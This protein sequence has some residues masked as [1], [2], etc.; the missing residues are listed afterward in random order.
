MICAGKYVI[1]VKRISDVHRL[2]T[3][4][5]S[6]LGNRNCSVDRL[7]QDIE[8]VR[9]DPLARVILVGDIVD[10]ICPADK[11]WDATQI[12]DGVPVKALADWGKFLRLTAEK[13]FKPI[14]HK[15][16]GAVYGNHEA[17]FQIRCAE[18]IH[19]AFC[20]NLGV[21]N[22]GYSCFLDLVFRR[23]V[24]GS[25]AARSYRIFAHHGAGAA[26]T[27]GGKINRLVAF[28]LMAEADIYVVGHVHEKDVKR[29][30]ALTADADCKRLSSK[31]RLGVFSGTY[32]RTYA[33]GAHAGYGE[34]AGYR[35]VPLGCSVIEFQPFDHDWGCREESVSARVAI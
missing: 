25:N 30:E 18:Q 14:K 12:P 31:K 5:D 22:F 3:I 33:E 23:E 32:L 35:P 9:R 7:E 21:P 29:M 2:Y 10:A 26:Q 11:R 20:E 28:M 34:R 27:A 6:H 13:A 4:G 17:T 24:K 1:P 16:I 8:V 15:V 19:A